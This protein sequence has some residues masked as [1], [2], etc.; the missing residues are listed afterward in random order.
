MSWSRHGTAHED[1]AAVLRAFEALTDPR[2]ADPASV[3]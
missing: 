2:G 3:R 1:M